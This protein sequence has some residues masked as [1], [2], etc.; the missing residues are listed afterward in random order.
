MRTSGAAGALA[1]DEREVQHQ[2][3]RQRM[4]QSVSGDGG[5]VSI[6]ITT[7]IAERLGMSVEEAT[8]WWE[9]KLGEASAVRAGQRSTG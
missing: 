8:A 6:P 4:Q 5:D 1:R 7:L 9:E 3:A 2:V